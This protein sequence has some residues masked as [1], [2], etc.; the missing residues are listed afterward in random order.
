MPCISDMAIMSKISICFENCIFWGA[1]EFKTFRAYGAPISLHILVKAP[2]IDHFSIRT[3]HE[4][5]NN[6]THRW[7]GFYFYA[8]NIFQMAISGNFLDTYHS[9]SY[10]RVSKIFRHSFNWS[11]W[12]KCVR[13]DVPHH[14]FIPRMKKSMLLVNFSPWEKIFWGFLY[15]N[16]RDVFFK[17]L[18]PFCIHWH[19]TTLCSDIVW[20]LVFLMWKIKNGQ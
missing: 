14:I 2:Y 7:C 1:G 11:F 16:Y 15:R 9:I 20:K 18:A 8:Q 4:V 5:C 12:E 13:N 6:E 19:A 10:S 3:L 17:T